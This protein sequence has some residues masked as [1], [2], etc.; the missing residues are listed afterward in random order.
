ML[1]RWDFKIFLNFASIMEAVSGILIALLFTRLHNFFF[2][3]F[4]RGFDDFT[5]K[6]PWLKRHGPT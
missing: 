5:A 4:D 3:A 1:L 6:L 2:A